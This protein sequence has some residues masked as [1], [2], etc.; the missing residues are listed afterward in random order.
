MSLS[1]AIMTD[2]GGC[3]LFKITILLAKSYSIQL[4]SID[5]TTCICEGLSSLICSYLVD[6]I[7]LS[8]SL[9]YFR[10]SFSFCIFCLVEL[11]QNLHLQQHKARPQIKIDKIA[12]VA[13][14]SIHQ[15]SSSSHSL[16]LLSSSSTISI[17]SV[18]FSST[19]SIT[20]GTTSSGSTIGVTPSSTGSVVFFFSSSSISLYISPSLSL[21]SSTSLSLS[22]SA[23]LNLCS[24]SSL[25][26]Y[27][28]ASLSL[29]SSSSLYF[30][31]TAYSYIQMSSGSLH[32]LKAVMYSKDSS[33]DPTELF[34]IQPQLQHSEPPNGCSVPKFYGHASHK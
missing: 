17:T 8:L 28:S 7:I 9:F 24:S 3:S 30:L 31:I 1:S 15:P 32:T 27:S 19:G 34:H 14:L 21:C 23:S 5:P 11:W 20:T 26:L 10:K 18:T 13:I 25:S 29:Y 16:Q 4:T 6:S 12:I 33:A 2:I 22:S